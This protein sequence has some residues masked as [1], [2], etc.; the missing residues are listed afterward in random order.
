MID[1]GISFSWKSKWCW[2]RTEWQRW[3]SRIYVQ[4][5]RA[6]LLNNVNKIVETSTFN[7]LCIVRNT[8]NK[9]NKRSKS[10]EFSQCITFA[11]VKFVLTIITKTNRN[12]FKSKKTNIIHC[13][14]SHQTTY[15]RTSRRY[16]FN[17]AQY[18]KSFTWKANCIMTLWFSEIVI[19]WSFFDWHFFNIF[20]VFLSSRAIMV[21]Q[22]LLH[23]MIFF[24]L[25]EKC[26]H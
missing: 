12:I 2:F 5:Q 25:I 26:F 16:I 6:L 17:I 1:V 23:W 3:W 11:L 13:K 18:H 14:R 24:V 20:N 15:C 4:L 9:I 21:Y 10:T 19:K 22:L 8:K 7:R